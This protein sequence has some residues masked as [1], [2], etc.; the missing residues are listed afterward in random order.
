[1]RLLDHIEIT[2]DKDL[3]LQINVP[4]SPANIEDNWILMG[5][6]RESKQ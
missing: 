6:W 4:T 2:R 5:R 1:M 3:S